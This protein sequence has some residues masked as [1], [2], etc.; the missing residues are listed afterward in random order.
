MAAFP[1]AKVD[2]CTQ[3]DPPLPFTALLDRSLDRLE[4][5]VPLN[6]SSITFYIRR[7]H[8]S[9]IE[10]LE[11]ILSNNFIFRLGLFRLGLKPQHVFSAL[12]LAV[13]Y[14][15]RR[16]YQRSI[17]LTTNLCAVA[18]PAYCS[19]KTINGDP[20]SP[21]KGLGLEN[22][23]LHQY[24]YHGRQ[25]DDDYDDEDD[26]DYEE[27]DEDDPSLS[28]EDDS[29]Q[30]FSR[31]GRPLRRRY[32]RRNSFSSGIS[33]QHAQQQQ[34]SFRRRRGRSKRANKKRHSQMSLPQDRDEEDFDDDGNSSRRSFASSTWD[35]QSTEYSVYSEDAF[36]SGT[37]V[38]SGRYARRR[39]GASLTAEEQMRQR[40]RRR[41]ALFSRSRK[42]KATRQWLAYWS[43]YGT[44]QVLDTW[45]AF[46]LDWIP[47]Y[48]FGKLMFLWWAQ[49]SGA[50]LVFD[51]FRPLIQAKSKDG[52]E[53][54]RRPSL[55]SLSG[56]DNDGR[57]QGGTGGGSHGGGGV[58][59]SGRDGRSRPNS[60]QMLPSTMAQQKQQ[61]H[62]QYQQE[63]PQ[64]QQQLYMQQF[65]SERSSSRRETTSFHQLNQQ[66]QRKSKNVYNAYDDDEDD[67]EEEDNDHQ[68]HGYQHRHVLQH[69]LMTTSPRH[70][71][72]GIFDSTESVWSA[73]ALPPSTANALAAIERHGGTSGGG[74]MSF[75]P[76]QRQQQIEATESKLSSAPASAASTAAADAKGVTENLTSYAAASTIHWSPPLPSDSTDHA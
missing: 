31:T 38:R 28:D 56:V 50:T 44:V 54:A 12:C 64:Y 26:E 11:S 40:M 3:T 29:D 36:T 49:R 69:E 58:G 35:R 32:S 60:T 2:S 66:Q 25:Y 24:Y 22:H 16:L 51:Y 37:S 62:Q 33:S 14:L 7:H 18:Y 5:N 41:W 55:R 42:E 13:V 27:D 68:P 8:L 30:S 4:A 34:P 52:R 61:L 23:L 19:I 9:R 39:R 71:A 70:E 47:G 63:Q 1:R 21:P 17:Y 65:Y 46:L 75:S 73:P 48:H 74:M 10:R 15:C 43:I 76:S 57:G 72:G 53:V 67:D 59:G 45:S 20:I 6:L